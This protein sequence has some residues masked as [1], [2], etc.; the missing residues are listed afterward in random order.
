MITSST[1]SDTG[2]ALSAL[3]VATDELHRK[4]HLHPLIVELLAH[5][6]FDTYRMVLQSFLSFYRPLEPTLVECCYRFGDEDQ[7][8]QTTRTEQLVEDLEA[9]GWRSDRLT[10]PHE[11]VN[12]PQLKTRGALVGCLYVVRGSALGG[13]AILER[14]GGHLSIENCRRFLMND[15]VET[16]AC[17]SAFHA[18][19]ELVCQTVEARR[20]ATQ[21]ARQTFES[22]AECFAMD[23]N[24]G[25]RHRRAPGHVL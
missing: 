25:G 6:S 1:H 2:P 15:G 13:R 11:H 9:L 16:Q 5:P 24:L 8:F 12:L 4:L 7:Y 18:Y 23:R 10:G 3:R 21:T 20:A 22:I 17:W 14:I 19:C